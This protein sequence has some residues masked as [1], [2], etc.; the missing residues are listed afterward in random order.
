MRH[1]SGRH[2]KANLIIGARKSSVGA[3]VHTSLPASAIIAVRMRSHKR[4]QRKR[5]AGRAAAGRL[6]SFSEDAFGC[7]KVSRVVAGRHTAHT[8]TADRRGSMDDVSAADVDANMAD[9]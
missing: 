6:L 1:R 4:V 3:N 2:D 7:H 5:P 8:D 9:R